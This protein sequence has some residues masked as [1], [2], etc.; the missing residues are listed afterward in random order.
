M[1]NR[2]NY[3]LFFLAAIMAVQG[4]YASNTRQIQ[5]HKIIEESYPSLYNEII[6]LIKEYDGE[7]VGYEFVKTKVFRFPSLSEE[8]FAPVI[9][10]KDDCMLALTNRSTIGYFN[11][12]NGEIGDEVDI[13]NPKHERV[14]AHAALPSSE[15][16]FAI[17][18]D[19]SWEDHAGSIKILNIATKQM[20]NLLRIPSDVYIKDIVPLGENKFAYRAVPSFINVSY[21]VFQSREKSRQKRGRSQGDDCGVYVYDIQTHDATQLMKDHC[22]ITAI[23]S[24]KDILF[25]GLAN[26]SIKQFSNGSSCDL[27]QKN[28]PLNKYRSFEEKPYWHLFT[29][30]IS[31]SSVDY[32]DFRDGRIVKMLPLR[33]KI[34]IAVRSAWGLGRVM[35]F[36]DVDIKSK[37]I[38]GLRKK[39]YS[40]DTQ[41]LGR[42]S[43]ICPWG[44]DDIIM[45]ANKKLHK[46]YNGFL[47]SKLRQGDYGYDGDDTPE[48]YEASD[49]YSIHWGGSYKV[50]PYVQTI[51][52]PGGKIFCLSQD[53]NAYL[54]EEHKG[55]F[56]IEPKKI[57]IDSCGGSITRNFIREKLPFRPSIEY[58][59]ETKADSSLQRLLNKAPYLPHALAATSFGLGCWS[60]W[61]A[62]RNI[63]SPS[64]LCATAGSAF[65]V[66]LAA[67]KLYS[68]RSS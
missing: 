60:V 51:L 29:R 36:C 65:F 61:N 32:G 46:L 63:A 1:V 28:N 47:V 49:P 18:S 21:E 52:L 8:H 4:V 15:V 43:G 58:I 10:I 68:G 55:E 56:L 7:W 54:F 11:L 2:K 5:L 50:D 37:H 20:R 41:D 42:F 22:V 48:I 12:K 25:V 53:G 40:D 33:H 19:S 27:I 30:R 13:M 35:I 66:G 67:L 57:N 59:T 16:V 3:M 6:N 9:A 26:G 17:F 31:S 45:M 44:S 23:A 38:S 64:K 39:L 14:G 24:S 62:Y 34:I